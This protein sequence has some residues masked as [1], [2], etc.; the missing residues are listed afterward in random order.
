MYIDAPYEQSLAAKVRALTTERLRR[1]LVTSAAAGEGKSSVV[2]ALGRALAQTGT[3]SVLLVDANPDRPDLHRAFGVSPEL[4][5]SNLLESVY[6]FDVAKE[7]PKQFGLGDW[8]E[9]LR[10]QRKTGELVVSTP[11][12]SFSIRL[13]GGS[14][15]SIS[16]AGFGSAGTLGELLVGRDKISPAQRDAA[17]RIH[18][19]SGR[20]LGEVLLTLDYVR[21]RDLS[22]ALLAQ[23]GQALQELIGLR[24]PS[25]RFQETAEPHRPVTAGIGSSSPRSHDINE[26]VTG[27]MRDYLKS[28][29]ISSQIPV[30]LCDTPMS[31]LKLLPGGSSPADL[32]APSHLHA[33]GLLLE[34][35][36]H[37]F[38]IVLIDAAEVAL[39]SPTASIAGL[40]DGTVLVVKA[41][42]EDA[43]TIQRAVEE[44]RRSGSQVLGVVLNQAEGA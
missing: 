5:L 7:N 17:L 34:R 15:S 28:P 26:L 12:R 9:I 6:F 23:A 2:A 3:E 43:A 24:Q 11:E 36:G 22:Q 38:D 1:L 20:P 18:Q 27:G 44:L 21:E 10:A 39:T 31:N 37:V 40:L 41:D 14:V 29:F 16:E 25:C 13:V 32:H 4:G 35:L 8:L 42:Q 19:E 30:Y 33:L